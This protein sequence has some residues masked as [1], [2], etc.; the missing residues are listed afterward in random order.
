MQ[1]YSRVQNSGAQKKTPGTSDYGKGQDDQDIP[2]PYKDMSAI[3]GATL[4]EG[5]S[6]KEWKKYVNQTRREPISS[7]LT[8]PPL[9]PSTPITF[10][11]KNVEGVN[12][13]HNNAIVTMPIGNCRVSRVLLTREVVLTSFTDRHSIKWKTHQRLPAIVV[14]SGFVSRIV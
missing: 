2:P 12:F 7:A 14:K 9:S 11:D 5:T 8:S 3:F 13:P 4:L 1:Q 6:S 10:N